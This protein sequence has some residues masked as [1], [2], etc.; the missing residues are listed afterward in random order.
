MSCLHLYLQQSHCAAVVESVAVASGGE[1]N[2]VE[3][4]LTG[5]DEEVVD[6]DGELSYFHLIAGS[7]WP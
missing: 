3:F 1:L 5:F 2:D 6:D 4:V 7:D